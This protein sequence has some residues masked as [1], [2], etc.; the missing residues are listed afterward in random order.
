MCS[1]N[2]SALFP[3]NVVSVAAEWYWSERLSCMGSKYNFLKL[4]LL[5]MI[6]FLQATA[7]NAK[8]IDITNGVVQN[9]NQ[10]C[11]CGFGTEMHLQ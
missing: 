7:T 4:K 5:G 8:L 2:L 11:R 3:S 9:I 1:H 6:N 10:L